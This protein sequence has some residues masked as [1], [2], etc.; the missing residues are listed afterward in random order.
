MRKYEGKSLK[1]QKGVT[2]VELMLGLVIIAVV[3]GIGILVYQKV[4]ASSR[5]YRASAGILALTAGVK[6]IYTT[7]VYTN[8]SPTVLIQANK[9]P[10]DMV[11]SATTLGSLWGGN[12]LLAA[13]NYNGGTN[14][15]IQITYPSVPA[16]ECNSVLASLA[17]NF[18]KI[19][20]GSGAGTVVKDDSASPAVAFDPAVT[21]GVC[22]NT[23]NTLILVTT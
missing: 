11:T 19:T 14:N 5:A 2:L 22:N 7:P 16:N 20:A 3:L 8:I 18:Q 21:A 17:P 12:V 4:Q 10:T 23:S 15:A 6:G 13:V 1:K 9:A